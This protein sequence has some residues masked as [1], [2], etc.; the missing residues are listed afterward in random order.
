MSRLTDRVRLAA[1]VSGIGRFRAVLDSALRQQPPDIDPG[2]VFVIGAPRSGTSV[3]GWSLNEHPNLTCGPESEIFIQQFGFGR[4]VRDY[5][6]ALRRPDGLIAQKQV[7]LHE[8]A[9]Y[10]GVGISELYSDLLG[11]QRW[12]DTTPRHVLMARELSLLQP[13]ARFLFLLRNGKDVVQSLTHSGFRVWSAH[14]FTLAAL[15]WRTYIK[16]GL[17]FAEA[18]P[19]RCRTLRYETLQ[20]MDQDA[21][22]DLL[23]FLQLDHEPRCRTFLESHVINSSFGADRTAERPTAASWSKLKRRQFELIA[24]PLMRELNYE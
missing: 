10:L 8:Y 14:S 2:P 1:Q 7:A 16:A 18:H 3:L 5:R 19:M 22:A 21:W 17:S 24:G 12:I 15:T 6:A 11:G 20:Q 9:K 13:T 23:A 4:L